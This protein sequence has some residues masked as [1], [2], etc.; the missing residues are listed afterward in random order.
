M[1]TYCWATQI[2]SVCLSVC[3]SVYLSIYL[4][5]YPPPSLSMSQTG[6]TVVA[7]RTAPAGRTATRSVDRV[8][9][10]TVHTPTL[11]TTVSPVAARRTRCRN[12]SSDVIE[13]Y[14]YQRSEERREST[15]SNLN[16]TRG[17]RVMAKYGRH[18]ARGKINCRRHSWLLGSAVANLGLIPV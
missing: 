7:D 17:K 3:L 10:S 5:I 15:D 12:A 18:A 11:V 2:I 14:I 13:H 16:G 9:L 4:S 8:T 1:F 6:R